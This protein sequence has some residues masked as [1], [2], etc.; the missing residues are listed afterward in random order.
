M[1]ASTAIVSSAP[2]AELTLSSTLPADRN[3]ATVYLAGIGASSRRVLASDLQGLARQLSAG[4]FDAFTLPWWE[5]RYQHTAALRAWLADSG[6]APAT[7]NRI[8]SAL[9]GV[10]RACWRLGLMAA[11]DYQAAA[12]V[13]ALPG[14]SNEPR[15]R[16]LTTDEKRSLLA[17]CAAD[18]SPAGYRDAAMLAL[19]LGAGGLRRAEMIG[20]NME[21]V[22]LI[23]TDGGPWARVAVSGKRG[24]VRTIPVTNG[25][26]DALLD[27]LA[28]RGTA[29]GPLFWP[30]NKGQRMTPARLSPGA[31]YAMT[32][33]RAAEAAIAPFGPHDLRRTFVGDL[34]DAG[35]DIA[36]VA[37]L[38]GHDNVQTT[39]RYDRRGER[40]RRAAVSKLDLP[41]HRRRP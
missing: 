17:V 26:L 28:V 18:E 15:G 29:P 24:K 14:G 27:W 37:A 21:D 40:T 12:D 7:V 8:L 32:R 36:T 41:Y 34:L 4:R 33:K 30:V 13:R 25:A 39:S 31:V 19:A 2:P 22:H 6:R 1:T 10:L 9:R 11:D 5:L 20:L 38:A 16:A 23:E 3:P 35:A